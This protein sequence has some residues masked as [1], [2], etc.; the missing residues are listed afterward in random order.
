M[1]LSAVGSS[2][3]V[4]AVSNSGTYHSPYAC[5]KAGDEGGGESD[6]HVIVNTGSPFASI[7]GA[8]LSAVY[9]VSPTQFSL[10]QAANKHLDVTALHTTVHNAGRWLTTRV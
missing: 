3:S 10:S 4:V 6:E 2:G 7:A 1:G 8:L 9:A 5:T